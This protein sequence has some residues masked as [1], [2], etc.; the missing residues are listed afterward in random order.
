MSAVSI[1]K[2]K[3][4][5]L[6]YILSETI[7]TPLVSAEA[8]DKHFKSKFEIKDIDVERIL[9]ELTKSNHICKVNLEFAAY[10]LTDDG[11]LFMKSTSF[12]EELFKNS[13][14]S[15]Q[16]QSDKKTER[17]LQEQ[18]VSEARKS[19]DLFAKSNSIARSAVYVALFAI[20]ISLLSILAALM[21]IDLQR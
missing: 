15:I 9:L 2:A 4:F 12:T 8:I 3:D 7:I 17:R 10:K 5:A 21:A 19:N 18:A 13:F 1:A 11:K 14:R 20:A 6:E 16:A